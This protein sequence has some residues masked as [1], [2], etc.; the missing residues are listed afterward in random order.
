MLTLNATIMRKLYIGILLFFFVWGMTACFED[1]STLGTIDVPDIE[2]GELRDTLITSYVGNVLH[3]SPEVTTAYP[4][5]DLTYAWYYYQNVSSGTDNDLED[6]FR[7]NKIS[8]TKELDYEVNLGTGSY[9]IV[10][11]VTS[12]TNNYSATA[13]MTLTTVTSFSNGFYILKETAEGGTEVDLLAT[14]GLIEGL[15]SNVLGMPLA[16]APLNLSITY[17]HPYINPDDLQ[18]TSTS[19]LHVFSEGDYRSFRTEDM[20]ETF[21]RETVKF[22]AAAEEEVFGAMIEDA[23]G[24]LCASSKG[25]YRIGTTTGNSGKIGMPTLAGDYSHF[26]YQGLS[27]GLNG[28]CVWNADEHCLYSFYN[29]S[30]YEYE[31][32]AGFTQ[33]NL[34]YVASSVCNDGGGM[35]GYDYA[36]YIVEDNATGRR[37][38]IIYAYSAFMG[39]SLSVTV[40]DEGLHI[41]NG[42]VIAGVGR[43]ATIIYVVDGGQLYFYNFLTNE[44]VP[45]S[46]PGLP[47]GEEIAYITNQYLAIVD[48]MGNYDAT[49]SENYLI[50]A[51]ESGEGYK[52]YLYDDLVGGVPNA[53]PSRTA[54]GTGR[55]KAVRYLSLNASAIQLFNYFYGSTPYPFGD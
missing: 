33:E 3:V 46:L 31:L 10:L 23:N 41:A 42:D 13:S 54:S 40:L 4:E 11:E 35:M 39:G 38:I 51:T 12:K 49:Q 7:T 8:D 45:V 15:M 55:V 27:Y 43:D 30:P 19:M 22:E 44:E 48:F 28:D 36:W 16:G 17:N 9:T 53:A 52:L 6:G 24:I 14:D 37:A 1:D 5:S 50:V 34:E 32:P 2:I 47:A 25:I 18:M 20:V 29:A 21:N 26:H